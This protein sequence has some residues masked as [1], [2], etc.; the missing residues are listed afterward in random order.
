MGALAK[1]CPQLRLVDLQG[2]SA[3]G[4]AAALKLAEGCA[5]LDTARATALEGKDRI[6]DSELSKS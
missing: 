4:D 6:L 2:C 5:A 1:G 3:V